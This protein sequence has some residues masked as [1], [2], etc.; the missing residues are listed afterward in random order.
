MNIIEAYTQTKSPH[1]TRYI[2]V[3]Q[4]TTLICLLNSTLEGDEFWM[5]QLNSASIIPDKTQPNGRTLLL[6]NNNTIDAIYFCKSEFNISI[7]HHLY[8]SHREAWISTIF[9]FLVRC[10]PRSISFE[11]LNEVGL[12]CFYYVPESEMWKVQNTL[13]KRHTKTSICGIQYMTVQSEYMRRFVFNQN[14]ELIHE[15]VQELSIVL[16]KM[17][18]NI[19]EM[20]D[21]M[22]G[23]NSF[24]ST[25]SPSTYS[26]STSPPK[27]QNSF[28][29]PTF[30]CFETSSIFG[31]KF[32]FE[33]K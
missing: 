14:Y 5:N 10:A 31:G 16:Q 24:I 2:M 20:L 15:D 8:G 3:H 9:E 30:P 33:K 26:P 28:L 29:N 25:Y 6:L 19:M 12:K 18:M 27:T 17:N 22:R 4:G 1:D 23:K 7:L 32:N 21:T 13:F 11:L